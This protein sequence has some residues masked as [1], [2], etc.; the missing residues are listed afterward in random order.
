MRHPGFF[1]LVTNQLEERN[2]EI[3]VALFMLHKHRNK[4]GF[5]SDGHVKFYE[6]RFGTGRCQLFAIW[7]WGNDLAFFDWVSVSSPIERG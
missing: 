4:V 3:V 2:S 6:H 7:A 1:S 5:C